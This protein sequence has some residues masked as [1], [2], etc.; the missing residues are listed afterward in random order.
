MTMKTAVNWKLFFVLFAASVITSMMVLPYIFALNPAVAKIFTPV[1][2]AAQIIQ[3]VML[4]SIAIFSGLYLAKRVGF[5]VPILE[6][7][8]ERKNMRAYLKSIMGVSIGTGVLAGVLIV[9]LGFLFGNASISLFKT[10]AASV[11]TWKGFLASFYGGIAEEILFRL[12][13]TTLFV[14]ISFKIRKTQDNRPTP[15]GIWLS[16]VL[17]AVI[18][19]LG[20]LPITGSLTSITPVIIL[21]AVVLNGVGAVIFGWLY[22]KNGLESAIISHFSADIVLH[23]I[24]PLLIPL[25]M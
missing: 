7:V 15:A 10:E 12:F 24:L 19:G 11:A 8:L 18:F 20:H 13:L 9:L 4:F 21:R 22:V 5:G 1:V 25:F 2:A 17:V 6:G 16:I 23:V 3:T 14:W